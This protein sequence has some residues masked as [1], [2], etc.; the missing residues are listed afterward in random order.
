MPTDREGCLQD[1]HWSGGSFG[2]FPSYALGNAYG[3]Q[4]LHNMKQTV[5]VEGAAAKGDLRPITAW[6]REKVHQYGG[7]MVPADVVRNACGE[8]DPAY[9][10]DYLT[11]KYTALYQL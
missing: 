10:T 8:F 1:S 4:M 9:Y 7:L 11:R 6:L 3:A 2:Y 5:D